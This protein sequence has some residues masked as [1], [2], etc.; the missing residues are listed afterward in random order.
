MHFWHPG[1]ICE[2]LREFLSDFLRN[3][4]EESSLKSLSRVETTE[5]LMARLKPRAANTYS[6]GLRADFMYTRN[7]DTYTPQDARL[8]SVNRSGCPT[9]KPCRNRQTK[10]GTQQVRKRSMVAKSTWYILVILRAL[11]GLEDVGVKGTACWMVSTT[12]RLLPRNTSWGKMKPA[13]VSVT[14]SPMSKFP[15]SLQWSVPLKSVSTAV[16]R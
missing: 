8:Y 3:D 1:Y 16:R 11:E 4:S 13:I 5:A 15:L 14:N 10:Y 9:D 12:A 7:R 2:F 6:T